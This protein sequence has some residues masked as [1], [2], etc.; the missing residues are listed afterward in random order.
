M[1]PLGIIVLVQ[2]GLCE[3]TTGNASLKTKQTSAHER[4]DD[5]KDLVD[6]WVVDGKADTRNKTRTD[7]KMRG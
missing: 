4:T 2:A 1:I 7:D 5:C 3:V 6:E